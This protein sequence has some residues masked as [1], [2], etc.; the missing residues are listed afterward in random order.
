VHEA[1]KPIPAIN[2]TN[3][4]DGDRILLYRIKLYNRAPLQTIPINAAI[5]NNMPRIRT[6]LQF[7]GVGRLQNNGS[8]GEIFG[9]IIEE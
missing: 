5:H 2:T 6:A 3:I 1:K 9:S 7:T 4:F 8:S